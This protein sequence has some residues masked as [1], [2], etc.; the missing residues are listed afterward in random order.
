M[1]VFTTI[2][3]D[4]EFTLI[5]HVNNISVSTKRSKQLIN[6]H[7]CDYY[8]AYDYIEVRR[9]IDFVHCGNYGSL[10]IQRN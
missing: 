9:G 6:S 3:K 2:G 8:V 10:S 7:I 5:T 1:K 4:V